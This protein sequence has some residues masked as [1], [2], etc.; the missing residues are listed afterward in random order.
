MNI[1]SLHLASYI[2]TCH[3]NYYTII[4]CVALCSLME[5][6][7]VWPLLAIYWFSVTGLVVAGIYRVFSSAA[8]QIQKSWCR[9]NQGSYTHTYVSSSMHGVAKVCRYVCTACMHM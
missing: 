4:L 9:I 7:I 5:I 8:E 1:I 2:A 3:V 6:R